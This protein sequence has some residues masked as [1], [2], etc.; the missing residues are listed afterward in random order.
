MNKKRCGKMLEKNEEGLSYFCGDAL[1]NI[2]DD[3]KKLNDA[4]GELDA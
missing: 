4:S 1:E 2:C 3:C